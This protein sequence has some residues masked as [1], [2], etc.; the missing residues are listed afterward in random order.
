MRRVSG[1]TCGP[2]NVIS[3]L[4]TI[5]SQSADILLKSICGYTSAR[6]LASSSR[7][8]KRVMKSGR[9]SYGHT[10]CS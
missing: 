3:Y 5:Q 8:P 9:G 6:R 2:V 7:I 4:Y 1:I 10:P